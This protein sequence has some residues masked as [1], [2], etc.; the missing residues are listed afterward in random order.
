MTKIT[1]PGIYDL[2]DDEYFADPCPAPSLS[3]SL[4]KI[5][6]NKSPAHAWHGS[7][8]LNPYF[9]DTNRKEFDLGKAAHALLLGGGAKIAVI[10]ADSYRTKAAREERDAAYA[11]GRTPIL[12]AQLYEVEA[13]VAA[14]RRQL[15][16]HHEARD[17]FVGGYPE[18]TIVWRAGEIWCRA[19]LDWLPPK[20][21][22]V[23]YDY[24]TEGQD[25]NP[26]VLSRTAFNLGYDVQAAFYL[27]GLQAL[28]LAGPDARFRFVVQEREAPYAL[29]VIEI[30]AAAMEQA[31]R[32]IAA[33]IDL[34]AECLRTNQWP[35]YPAQVCHVDA[36]MWVEKRWLDREIREETY[37]KPDLLHWQAPFGFEEEKAS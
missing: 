32:K 15:A 20:G 36:P 16:A 21:A 14:A 1:E 2:T 10:D 5:L 29:S 24:K 22:Q 17:A 25:A 33:A 19:K 4:A 34:W 8:R 35:G 28:R 23:F 18:R 26:E 30:G 12:A 11:E 6:L 3:A 37:G 9:E 13:M 31:K 27:M 7:Q